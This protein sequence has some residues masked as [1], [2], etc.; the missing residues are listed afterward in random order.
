MIIEFRCRSLS[1]RWMAD[2]PMSVERCR[3][4]AHT[5]RLGA[6]DPVAEDRAD[7]AHAVDRTEHASALPIGARI[8]RYR[9]EAV[10]GQG[11]FG[12]TYRAHDLQLERDVAVKEYLPALVA[13]RL[14]GVTVLPRST[15]VAAD[16]AWG[17]ARFLDEAKT[18]A[19]LARAPAVVQVHDYLEAN[20]TAYMVM[21]LVEGETLAS[22]CRREGRLSPAAVER[23]VPSLLDGLQ[24]IHAAGV[25]HR[26]IKPDNIIVAPDGAPTLIDFGASRVAIADR[27]Q[28]LTAVYTP[29]YAAPEQ[30][31]SGQQGPYTDIY[32]LAATLYVCVCGKEPFGATHRVL[33]GDAMPSA[34]DVAGGGYGDDL[35]SAI[36]AGLLLQPDQRPQ[37]IVAWR[38]V[39]ATGRWAGLSVADKTVVQ[40]SARA[41]TTVKST[42]G[43]AAR[44]RPWGLALGGAAAVAVALVGGA[45]WWIARDQP[46]QQSLEAQL[47]AALARSIPAATP[48]FRKE[49]AAAFAGALPNRA[50]A[51]A[52]Q[53]GKLRWTSEW[54]TREA[55][56]EKALERCQLAYDEPCM[57]VAV[58]DALL[59]SGADA[60]W[61]V[62]DAPRTRYAG[63]LNLERMPAVRPKELQRPEIANYAAAGGPKALALNAQGVLTLATG[64]ATQRAAEE[65]ALRA[66]R[67]EAQRPR[68]EGTCYLYAAE[69]RVVLPLKATAPL[70]AAPAAAP[71]AA[72]PAAVAPPAAAPPAAAPPAAAP[73][74]AA[75][76]AAQAPPAQPA[77]PQAPPAQAPPAE[78]TVRARLLDAFAKIL[79][80]QPAASRE[81]QVAGYLSAS[82]HK[83]LAAHPPSGS[84][85]TNGW[86]NAGL[87]EERTLEGCQVRYGAPCLLM[88]VNDG[89]R[90]TDGGAS[91][92]LMPRVEYDGVFDPQK[93]PAVQATLRQRADVAGYRD[94]AGAKAAAFHPWGRLFVVSG[95]NSPRQAEERALAECNADPQRNNMDGPCYLYA[96]GDRVVLPRRATAPIAAP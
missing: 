82:Q 53:G 43:G 90:A 56:E 83:A 66:C 73:P 55:A 22:R 58:N 48:T 75:P 12:I 85:R 72:A 33:N 40:A 60:S 45:L 91:R 8:G 29:R 37:T 78:A 18:L 20:G 77:S 13:T 69:N 80:S 27:T 50:L 49:T 79:A 26:D 59:P 61:P 5:E 30:M 54:P 15:Q 10:L 62:R 57:L 24:Q 19:R 51:V 93:I 81:S 1:S 11:A 88:A 64:A 42:A 95:A 86:A 17:R 87:A 2:P 34:R 14:D 52:R 84:W 67:S 4:D 63:T 31:T 32:A 47:D 28:A 71:P 46:A 41:S 89:L 36:D 23:L 92:R 7:Q 21:Q 9:I 16:F 39:F 6:G 94:A 76:S 74:A 38:E 44:R 35:L 65:Q 3:R 96:V 70:A 68:Q 25:L